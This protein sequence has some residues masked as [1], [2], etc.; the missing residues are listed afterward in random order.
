MKRFLRRAAVFLL[1]LVLTLAVLAVTP[2]GSRV[3][4]AGR[5]LA[6]MGMGSATASGTQADGRDIAEN[7]GIS[8]RSIS[9]GYE[10]R[11][12][13]ADIYETDEVTSPPRAALVLVP[14]LA[15]RGKEDP[16][17]VDLAVAMAR[18]R[19]TVLVPNLPSL[20][21]QRV[22]ADNVR[23]IA[24]AI[25]SAINGGWW[26]SEPQQIPVGVAAIS[27]AVG[28][29]LLA[30][31]EP[32]IRG[33]V[34]FAIAVGG[35][36]DVDAVLT[37]FTTGF[38]RGH[39]DGAWIKGDP[40]IYGKWLF[41]RANAGRILTLRDRILLTAIAGRKMDNPEA[42]IGDL[43]PKLGD[44]GLSV[45]RLLE[46][47]DP[48]KAPE[49]IAGLPPP[50]LTDLRALDLK[51]HDLTGLP[52]KVMLLHGRDDPIIPVG[53]SEQLAE[54]LPPGTAHLFIVD[55]LGHADLAPGQWGDILILGKAAY[56]L[57]SWRDGDSD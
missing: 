21:E 46:N 28:P 23:Q 42:N 24:D 9:F 34:D 53:Q 43:V 29:A 31:T 39:P 22:S 18:A 50:L 10:G 3:I 49:L 33:H 20:M 26:Y 7:R 41:V 11:S 15:P 56:E 6:D 2:W 37:Y 5:L 17:L 30:T 57:L 54:I 14:G 55:N 16:R 8:R 52:P 27:Y 35:Y 32:D 1:I 44:E 4:A 48:D 19:F 47:D 25:G 38:Y 45:M 36:Y 13:E 40:N 51:H 12:Y